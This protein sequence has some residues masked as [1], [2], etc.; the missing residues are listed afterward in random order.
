ML[1]LAIALGYDI[2]GIRWDGDRGANLVL[3]E[4]QLAAA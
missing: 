2:V 3:C 4:K 1:H